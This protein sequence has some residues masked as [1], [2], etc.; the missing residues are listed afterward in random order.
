MGPAAGAVRRAAATAA[1]FLASGIMHEVCVYYMCVAPPPAAKGLFLPGRMT[2]FFLLQAPLIA[3]ERLA[4]THLSSTLHAGVQS[5]QALR[6]LWCS[7]SSA[8]AVMRAVAMATSFTAT[9][10]LLTGMAELLFWPAFEACRVDSNGIAEFNRHLNSYMQRAT[11][12][13]P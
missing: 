3:A 11:L 12:Q 13:L 10:V 1:A 9:A 8:T 2:A 4:H 5:S 6:R 7:A